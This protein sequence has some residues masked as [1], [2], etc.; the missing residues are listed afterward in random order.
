MN[1]PFY[2]IL[3]FWISSFCTFAQDTIT[4]KVGQKSQVLMIAEDR[5]SLNNLKKV[6]FNQIV[7]DVLSELDSNTVNSTE[8][9]VMIYKYRFNPESGLVK[10]NVEQESPEERSKSEQRKQKWKAFFDMEFSKDSCSADKKKNKRWKDIWSVDFGLNNYQGNQSLPND[11]TLNTWGSRYFAITNFE[12]LRLGKENSPWGLQFGWRVSWHNF[13][14]ENNNRYLSKDDESVLL[15]DYE[16]DFGL[17]L[18]K[19]KFVVTYLNL[20]IM[21]NATFWDKEKKHKTFE[22][23]VGGSIGY[24]LDSYTKVKRDNT[25][26]HTHKDFY[27]TNFR[28]GLE[29]N[30]GFRDILVFFKYDLNPLFVENKAPELNTFSFGFVNVF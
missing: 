4:I 23:A 22:F 1:K 28:Y 20:P 30:M 18:S 21:F 5:E 25:R 17:G 16:E 29:A 3:S 8:E 26:E 15:N 13:M 6:D 9:K 19:S 24:R 27:L 14:L 10:I 12:R 7:L 11:Y 2:F